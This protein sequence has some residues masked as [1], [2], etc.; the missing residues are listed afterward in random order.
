MAVSKILGSLLITLRLRVTVGSGVD[1]TLGK[2]CRFGKF[3]AVLKIMHQTF[4]LPAST[5]AKTPVVAYAFRLVEDNFR[6]YIAVC[7]PGWILA[8]FWNLGPLVVFAARQL[9]RGASRYSGLGSGVQGI[10]TVLALPCQRGFSHR[11]APVSC[12]M[13]RHAY[14]DQ[15]IY[16]IHYQ[17]RPGLPSRDTQM[18]HV[19]LSRG[20]KNS[21]VSSV[22]AYRVR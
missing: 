19:R 12:G 2:C 4:V 20:E 15:V 21:V 16:T 7:D 14:Q 8:L 11:Q 5:S 9:Q 10:Q 22:W 6:R 17:G 3:H 1:A 13:G 18:S